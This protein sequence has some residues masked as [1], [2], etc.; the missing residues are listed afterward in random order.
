MRERRKKNQSTGKML[1][2]K[3][4]FK[5]SEVQI[6]SR[7]LTWNRYTKKGK[8]KIIHTFHYSFSVN[9]QSIKVGTMI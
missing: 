6:L 4:K 1:P 5:E 7:Q 3:Y 9:Y 2:G 8:A